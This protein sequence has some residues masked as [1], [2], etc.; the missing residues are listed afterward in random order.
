VYA[1]EVSLWADAAAKS[2][3]NV[4]P[5]QNW[6]VSLDEA[7]RRADALAALRVARAKFPWDR[8]LRLTE[9]TYRETREPR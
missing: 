3:T 4:R 1:S 9:E 6:V 5:Y 7:G 2:Q 8:G